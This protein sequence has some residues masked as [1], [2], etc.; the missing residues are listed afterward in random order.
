M[1]KKIS[2]LC[3]IVGLLMIGLVSG[4]VDILQ[5]APL[6]TTTTDRTPDF[7]YTVTTDN[8]STALCNLT[9]SGST[10]PLNVNV[11]NATAFTQTALRLADG[12]YKWNVSCV[13]PGDPAVH[14]NTSGT[15]DL[16]VT[17]ATYSAANIPSVVI[18]NIVGILAALF[19]L[20]SIIVL[21]VIFKW[22]KGSRGK[23]LIVK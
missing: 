19:G 14:L 3:V 15:W 23:L 13:S 21:I 18:D 1:N 20:A 9:I 17:F 11:T 5:S 8:A 10:Q 6:N 7:I 4:Y 22:I 16:N 2:L 12:E